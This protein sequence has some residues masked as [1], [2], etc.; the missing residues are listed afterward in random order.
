MEVGEHPVVIRSIFSSSFKNFLIHGIF[1]ISFVCLFT[2]DEGEFSLVVEYSRWVWREL[3][4][5]SWTDDGCCGLFKERKRLTLYPWANQAHA[6]L[7][8]TNS[9][10]HDIW[11]WNWRSEADLLEGHPFFIFNGGLKFWF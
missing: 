3:D 11:R 7:I 9:V 4:R 6:F 8:I 10:Q 2:N 5:V 1:L